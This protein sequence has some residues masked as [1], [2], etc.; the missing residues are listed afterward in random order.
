MFSK[1]TIIVL[2]PES[3]SHAKQLRVPK[4]FI[5]LS[6]FLIIFCFTFLGWIIPHYMMIKAQMPLLAQLEKESEQQKRKFV[7]LAERIDKM[8][9]K[10]GELQKLDYG[11]KVMAEL[12][13]SE[14]DGNTQIKGGDYLRSTT[15]L[16][17]KL[18]PGPLI[19]FI[20]KFLLKKLVINLIGQ[21]AK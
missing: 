16:D 21:G 12:E 17:K 6:V 4:L 11:L 18:A 1:K 15:N 9:I 20:N 5:F 8:N 19:N 10:I 14:D 3:A 13:T 7:H 2:V